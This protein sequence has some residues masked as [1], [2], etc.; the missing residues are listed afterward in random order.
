MDELQLIGSHSDPVSV[1]K[2]VNRIIVIKRQNSDRLVP[3]MK[4]NKHGDKAD[5]DSKSVGCK[6]LITTVNSINIDISP[7]REVVLLS[8]AEEEGKVVVLA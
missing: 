4:Q 2:E 3:R 6:Q 1:S 8:E 5:G 7:L